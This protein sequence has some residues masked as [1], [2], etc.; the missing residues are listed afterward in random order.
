MGPIS[1]L[2]ILKRLFDRAITS[3]SVTGGMS[4][5]NF[6]ALQFIPQIITNVLKLDQI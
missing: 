4:L 2:V 6:L 3:G 1:Q 5:Q